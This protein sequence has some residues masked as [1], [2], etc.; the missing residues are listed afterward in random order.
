MEIERKFLVGALP[1]GLGEHEGVEIAQGY[2]A[3][4]EDGSEVRLRRGGERLSLTAKRGAGMVRGEYEI[5]LTA[6][7]FDALWPG[8]EGRRLVKRR[9]SLAADDDLIVELDVYSGAL[10][11]LLV[12]EVEFPSVEAARAFSTPAWFGAEVTEDP[13]YRNRRLAEEGLPR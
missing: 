3:A 1:P 8:T 4:G 7:Q 11:G 10:A 6:A 5:E 2:L 9:Y 13:R 12:A